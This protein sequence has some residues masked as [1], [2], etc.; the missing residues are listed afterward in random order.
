MVEEVP[1][2]AVYNLISQQSDDA[3]RGIITHSNSLRN[4]LDD[5]AE[6]A[7]FHLK[8]FRRSADEFAIPSQSRQSIRPSSQAYRPIESVCVGSYSLSLHNGGCPPTQASGIAFLVAL[9][10][11][12]AYAYLIDRITFVPGRKRV[13]F[14]NSRQKVAE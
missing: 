6:G 13:K 10:T 5:V 2:R 9:L 7:L 3:I 11:S 12:I 14:I 8:P 1:Y 4:T